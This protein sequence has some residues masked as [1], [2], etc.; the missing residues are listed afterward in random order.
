[1]KVRL[2]TLIDV[3][4]NHLKASISISE[5]ETEANKS[6]RHFVKWWFDLIK[7]AI[8]VV[9]LIRSLRP[10]NVCGNS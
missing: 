5:Y 9:A 7:N 10:S 3:I 2:G 6:F 4:R 1:M 8:L